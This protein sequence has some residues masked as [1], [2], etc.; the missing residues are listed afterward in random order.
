[1]ENQNFEVTFFPTLARPQ[2]NITI[3]RYHELVTGDRVRTQIDAIRKAD[4]EGDDELT[5]RL[6]KRLPSITAAAVFD[7]GR[8]REYWKL[9]TGLIPIDLD[10]LSDETLTSLLPRLRADVHVLH[11]A[12]SPRGH[13]LKILVPYRPAEGDLPADWESADRFYRSAYRQVVA[14]FERTYGVEVD[15]SGC[16][17]TRLTFLT[18]DPFAYLNTRAAPFVIAVEAAAV[19]ASVPP[20]D[21]AEKETPAEPLAEGAAGSA[22]KEGGGA[23]VE[24]R[25]KS[26][27]ELRDEFFKGNDGIN[28]IRR[29]ML[30]E[31]ILRNLYRRCHRYKVGKRHSF[32]LLAACD[33]N[34][35]GVSQAES[36]RLLLESEPYLRQLEDDAVLKPA[37]EVIQLVRDVYASEK[38]HFASRKIAK[39]LMS[40]LYMK[41]EID[42]LFKLR[43]NTLSNRIEYIERSE[44]EQ[45]AY[46]FKEINDRIVNDLY[47]ASV[48]M[49]ASLPPKDIR[50][51]FESSF[52][53]TFDPFDSYL[54]ECPEWDG[55]D[56]LSD[57]ADSIVTNDPERFRRIFKMFVVAM[58]AYQHRPS[59][60]NHIMIVL[61]TGSQGVGKTMKVRDILPPELRNHFLDCGVD[62]FRKSDFNDNIAHK[63][64]IFCDELQ[65]FSKEDIGTLDF[66]VTVPTVSFRMPYGYFQYTYEHMAS[67]MGACN[68]T[69]FL[70]G[71]HGNR[72][73]H[74]FEVFSFEDISIN[75]RQMYA[76]VRH[77][78][79]TGFKYWFTPAEQEELAAYAY[80]YE[81][82]TEEFDTVYKYVRL[83]PPHCTVTSEH[84]MSEIMAHLQK[85]NKMI[86]G[87]RLS[88]TNLTYA[89]KRRRIPTTRKHSGNLYNCYLMSE[90]QAEYVSKYRKDAYLDLMFDKYVPR[91][92]MMAGPN[93]T[94]GDFLK[95]KEFLEQTD[96][97]YTKALRMY[98]EY[99]TIGGEDNHTSTGN[100]PF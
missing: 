31:I 7:G 38:E 26:V 68:D 86:S 37:G 70:S 32:L 79:A 75:Y 55:H 15:T 58:V 4:G 89:L 60:S 98:S 2:G 69:H 63:A 52:A 3:E 54:A 56:Y 95:A 35:Y 84:R 81:N 74:V 83:Y 97:D 76:Q 21:A 16:D 77:L 80:A 67:F 59:A 96:N 100:L 61:Y 73:Y 19:P 11:C 24:K 43:F 28:F 90:S 25:K 57:Y 36:E 82:N 9:L 93:G 47:D 41:V 23:A 45:G 62:L 14:Y 42:R 85:Y 10:G 72:R 78:I 87:D 18:S 91:E 6:K 88:S 71:K 13:G 94:E 17:I 34:A 8:R 49:G 53:E 44:F 27:R 50:S 64:I 92:V 66:D 22:D 46:L 40:R 12:L 51:I 20:S 1:M 99:M 5:A 29:R 48:E 33:L 30:F 65:K 39:D